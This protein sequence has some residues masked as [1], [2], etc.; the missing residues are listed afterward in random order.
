VYIE[1]SCY[2]SLLRFIRFSTF[3]SS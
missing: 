3:N 1:T 2:I